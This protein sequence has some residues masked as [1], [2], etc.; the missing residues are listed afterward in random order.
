MPVVLSA[1]NGVGVSSCCG[2]GSRSV[3]I[4]YQFAQGSVVYS[5]K[6][7]REGILEAIAIK[8]VLIKNPYNNYG[9]VFV[10]YQDTYNGLWNEEDLCNQAQAVSLATTYLE[11]QE[12]LL[13]NYLLTCGV[14]R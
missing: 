6:K 4:E 5:I 9:S 14:N 7:A 13:R 1:G 8:K 11:E 12:A 3:R 10:L 2:V